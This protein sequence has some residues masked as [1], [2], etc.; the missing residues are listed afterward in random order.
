MR[1]NTERKSH[2]F[3]TH[4]KASTFIFV[5]MLFFVLPHLGQAEQY[6]TKPIRFVVY[7]NPGG[8]IDVTI[9][10]LAQ[11]IE[12]SL[13]SEGISTPVIVENKSG[14]RGLVAI[15]YVLRQPADGHT[16][17]ALT[18]SV[19]SKAV[20]SKRTQQLHKLAMLVRLVDDYECLIVKRQGRYLKLDDLK[21]VMREPESRVLWVG[22]AIG[23]TDHLF[24]VRFWNAIGSRGTWIPYKSGGEAI[25]AL[26]GGH[27]DVY[28]GN[29]Q[30]VMGRNDLQILAVASP[31]R[32]PQFPAAVTFEESGVGELT[33]SSL[34]RG[35]AI[36][37]DTPNSI[38]E[39]ILGLIKKSTESVVWRNF[40]EQS[41]AEVI[42][43]SGKPFDDLV[44][45]QIERDAKLLNTLP[46]G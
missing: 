7:T 32:L 11:I 29:P 35:L 45:L 9:R 42:F 2:Y 33:G 34:W 4:R 3:K 31:K 14:A 1:E 10:K 27:A 15:Q 16:I 20:Q 36:H 44:A 40:I 22:P 26:L 5:A 28:V 12:E 38:R 30:D 37:H 46:R 8:L 25:G 24:A 23:G 43:E 18:S 6:P 19:I 13:E 41:G 21:N 17:F 39:Q